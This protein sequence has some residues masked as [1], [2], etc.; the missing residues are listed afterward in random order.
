LDFIMAFRSLSA[1]K[2]VRTA[3]VVLAFWLVT[4]SSHTQG[5]SPFA[6]LAGQW[7]GSGTV[8]LANGA[9]EPIKCRAAYDV[10]EEQNNL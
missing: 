5:A 1:G 3:I 6:K 8:E 9:R 4:T 7:A 10:L 2:A